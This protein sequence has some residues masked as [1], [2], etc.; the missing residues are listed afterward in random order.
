[1]GRSS[2][3]FEEEEEEES[4]DEADRTLDSIITSTEDARKRLRRIMNESRQE[5]EESLLSPETSREENVVEADRVVP[6]VSVWSEKSFFRRMARKAPGG[7]AFTPQPKFGRPIQMDEGEN[8][9]GEN[10]IR[11]LVIP[12]QVQ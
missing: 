5:S 6:D 12:K 4:I 8:D 1:M 7:W 2:A 11:D 9:G 3:P 10:Q